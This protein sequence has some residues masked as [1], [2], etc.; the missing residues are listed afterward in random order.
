M[1]IISQ[2][3]S[4]SFFNTSKNKQNIDVGH[5][6]DQ[7]RILEEQKK[8]QEKKELDR[9]KQGISNKFR[10]KIGVA[11]RDLEE[12]DK[13]LEPLKERK[14]KKARRHAYFCIRRLND[15]NTRIKF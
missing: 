1:N 6:D 7:K 2:I 8:I 4:I 11:I 13:E 3:L 15:I 9:V 10:G 5:P 12:L 14:Y